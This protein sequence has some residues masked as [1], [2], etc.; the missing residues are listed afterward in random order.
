MTHRGEVFAG[1]GDG[2]LQAI[3]RHQWHDQLRSD[4]NEVLGALVA[5]ARKLEPPDDLA[6]RIAANTRTEPSWRVRLENL[7]LLAESYP[8]NPAARE[9][10]KRACHDESDEVRLRAARAL[11]DDGRETI[12]RDPFG[13]LLDVVDE[14]PV[15]NGEDVYTT[16][17]HRLQAQ[18]EEV[19]RATRATWGA[20]GVTAIVLDP[21][22]GLGL[23]GRRSVTVIAPNGTTADSMTKG[24]SVLPPEQALKLVEDTPGAAAYIVILDKDEKPVVTASKRF[25]K[26]EAKE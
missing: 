15:E 19:L 16:I 12:V 3:F 25:P 13:R 6:E 24:V 11:G 21:K 9:A 23:T 14:E 22:T 4:L 26:F 17:D 20:K 1:R 8:D 5:V 18:V 7:S 2:H 10:L